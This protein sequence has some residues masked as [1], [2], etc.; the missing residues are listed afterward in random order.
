MS[1]ACRVRVMG[2]LAMYAEG[3]RADLTA[4]GYAAESANRN[5]RILAHVSR[6]MGGQGLSAGQ[7]ST[8]LLEEFLR[9]R[10]REG[11]RHALSIRA[12]MPLIS[13]LR[14]VGVGGLLPEAAVGGGTLDLVVEEY[15]RYLVGERALTADVVR[16]YTRLA[17]EFLT[18]CEQPDG[19]GL[20]ELSAASVTDY[21]V[22]QCRG[23]RPGSAKFLVTEVGA[24][25][26]V[27][28]WP[29]PAPACL[30]SA[31]GGPLGGG[32]SAPGAEPGDGGGAAG[33]L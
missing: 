27:P 26:L 5:L 6:W 8:G 25:V 24:Q 31:H 4:Q 16:G 29:H 2:P 22:A 12:V 7:L 28:D 30:R 18:A 33:Q 21:V 1:T 17:R 32:Q 15:R 11:Y 3:F 14:R 19:L 20:S 10:R 9:A 23:R 13:Y